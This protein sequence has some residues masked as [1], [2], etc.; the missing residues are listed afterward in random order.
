MKISRPIS[1]RH[2]A[3]VPAYLV[4]SKELYVALLK[5]LSSCKDDYGF[6]VLYLSLL[7]HTGS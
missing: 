1:S 6:A 2:S 7:L 5:T 3:E 4:T